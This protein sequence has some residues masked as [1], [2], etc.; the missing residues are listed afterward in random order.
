MPEESAGVSDSDLQWALDNE[1]FKALFQPIVRA[2]D[3]QPVSLEALARLHHPDHGTIQ[4][5]DFVPRMEGAGLALTLADQVTAQA[6][7]A[8]PRG[9]LQA[10]GLSVAV[11]LPLDVLLQDHA[12]ERIDAVR[13]SCEVSS[14]YLSIEL[15]ES[16]PVIDVPQ[17]AAAI[18]R[19]REA[20]YSLSLDD[21]GPEMP[22]HRNL[23]DLPF[24][25][26]KLDKLAVQACV[27]GPYDC[28]VRDTIRA[29]KLR[30]LSIV[31][32]GIEDEHTWRLLQ[33]MGAD[34][35]QGFMIARPLPAR[36]LS[37]WLENW[38]GHAR[39]KDTPDLV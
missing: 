28:F 29:A 15:T 5:D 30:G 17:L 37:G 32:E 2:E 39:F 23:L 31:A 9:F 10:N 36:G 3:G 11:N 18:E 27:D 26:I 38:K 1:R 22:R 8:V 14:R 19:W 12:L 7:A 24:T 20:G 6:L 21:V 34:L 33:D 13:E 35:M 25:T 16:Q 4:P